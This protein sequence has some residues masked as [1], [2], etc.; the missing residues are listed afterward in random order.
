M[1][2]ATPFQLSAA[3]NPVSGTGSDIFDKR[4]SF[5]FGGIALGDGAGNSWVS[6]LVRDVTVGVIVALLARAAWKYMK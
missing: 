6:G 1:A 3:V 5:D 2:G 4:S